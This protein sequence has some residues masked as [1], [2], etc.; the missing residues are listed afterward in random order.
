[1]RNLDRLK[2]TVKE[3]SSSLSLSLPLSL[4][5]ILEFLSLF[6]SVPNKEIRCCFPFPID[7]FPALYGWPM[8]VS[9]KGRERRG[10][11]E[12]ERERR[13]EPREELGICKAAAA[14]ER[15]K[16]RGREREIKRE[17]GRERE[18]RIS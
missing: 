6:V 11:R 12:R 5:L 17:V 9:E 15:E 4:S 16:E 13:G 18:R 8:G 1:M 2:R 7:R 14:W 3:S 10:G